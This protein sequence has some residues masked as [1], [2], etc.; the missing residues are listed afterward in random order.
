MRKKFTG[1]AIPALDT[2]CNK[3]GIVIRALGSYILQKGI[4]GDINSANT[5]YSFDNHCGHFMTMFIEIGREC[6]SVIE[7]KEYNVFSLV[8]RRYDGRIIRN[9]NGQRCSAVK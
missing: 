9:S 1:S 3:N 7:R 8:Y 2:V 6:G 4:I 5:L